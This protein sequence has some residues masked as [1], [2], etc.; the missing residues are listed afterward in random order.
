MSLNLLFTSVGRRVELLRI[1][2]DSY[3]KLGIEGR[4]IGTDID[5]LAP[6]LQLLDRSYLVPRSGSADIYLP[7]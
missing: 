1:F 2:N 6:A 5:P 3:R 7:D 4:I